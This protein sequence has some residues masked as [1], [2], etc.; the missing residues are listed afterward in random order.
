MS[1]TIK[2]RGY[3]DV[4][5]RVPHEISVDLDEFREWA[6][7]GVDIE[8]NEGCAETI[9]NF[10]VDDDSDEWVREW[11][12]ADPNEHEVSNYVLDEIEILEVAA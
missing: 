3:L 4:T 12:K 2:V 6:Y 11:P 10:I 1:G 7:A 5:V 8:I 9:R